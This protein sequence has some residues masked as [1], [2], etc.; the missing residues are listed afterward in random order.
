MSAEQ[1]KIPTSKVERASRVFRTSMKVGANYIKHN[2]QKAVGSQVD[3]N[4][5][6]EK[7]AEELFKL[8]S[9]LKGS[10]LKIAQM[11]SM[12][13]GL[14]PKAFADKFA[15]AQNS[16][17]ALSGPL[18]MNTFKKYIGKAPNEVFDKFNVN[19]VYAA[20]IG[21]VHEAW[22]DGH[23]LAVK[24][25]YPG[26]ADSIHSDINLVK[27]L[28]LRFIG[29][30]EKDVKQYFEEFEERLNEECDYEME[31]K[32]GTEI[33]AATQHIPNLI[34]PKYYKELSAKK[35]LTM[36]WIEAK[37]L[38]HFLDNETNQ[39]KKNQIGQAL[40]D[41]LH[42]SIHEHQRFH[43]D[44]HPG[45]FLV[46]AD[47]KLV[48]LDFGCVKTIPQDFYNFYFS[49]VRDDVF[50]DPQKL[51]QCLVGLDMLRESDTK[52]T[53]NLFFDTAVRAI[54]NMSL[55][56]KSETFY[57]GDRDFYNQLQTHGEEIMS[58]K[59]FRK[60]SAMRGSR[61]AIYLHRAF[62]G[63]YSILFKLNAT[64]NIDRRFIDKVGV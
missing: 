55:P 49:L 24:L 25:Q 31:L 16:A 2:A 53:E 13:N 23:K 27:P 59:E 26:V 9:Q 64:V 46:T 32:N 43:A 61:H 12:D 22:K 14:L 45:N 21:Q 3:E 38:Q 11:M 35:I 48:V 36:E 20:S 50:N 15:L 62:F 5:L 60:P 17:M 51:R 4:S 58:N 41:F 52:E 54:Q 10:A 47:N 37:P 63:L 33:A 18:V 8:M 34:I 57:F 19:A 6:N 39:D 1:D 40:L 29:V 7:N 56:M 28:V 44:P 42:S 30:K